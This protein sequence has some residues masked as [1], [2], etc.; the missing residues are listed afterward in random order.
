M[1]GAEP[2][3][4]R[5]VRGGGYTP[6]ERWIVRFADGSSAFAKA[7]VDGLT[8]DWLRAEHRIYDALEGPFLPAMFGWQDGDVPIL[9]L[10]DLSSGHWPPPWR[11]DQPGRV[12]STLEEVHSATPPAG[13]PPLEAWRPRLT[14]WIHVAADP[15]SFLALGLC[16]SSWLDRALP[17]LLEA[18]AR[19]D[20]GGDSLLHL[21]VRSDN[22]CFARERTLLVDWNL[23]CVGNAS[24]DA[25]A[26]IPSLIHEW[27][28]QAVSLSPHGPELATLIVGYF[29]HG[30][31]LPIIPTAPRVRKVQLEQLIAG[32][33]W[34]ARLLDLPVPE[35]VAR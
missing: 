1:A 8:A 5:R 25:V 28:P 14:C 35:P 22:I 16:S 2:A 32:L 12:L 26:W 4:W 31:R 27:G 30:A 10:E 18:E 34:V 6:A 15:G 9:L 23:A 29:A 17:D 13:L 20:L 21:D 3:E 24:L 33:P 11:E 7:A 19:A